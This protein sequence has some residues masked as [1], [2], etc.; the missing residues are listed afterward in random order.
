MAN[1]KE[2]RRQARFERVQRSRPTKEEK[3]LTRPVALIM[4]RAETGGGVVLPPYAVQGVA[5]RILEL[6]QTVQILEGLVD[7]Y[8]RLLAEDEGEEETEE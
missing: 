1:R 6:Q 3:R 8:Q 5:A 4:E 2:R 7:E